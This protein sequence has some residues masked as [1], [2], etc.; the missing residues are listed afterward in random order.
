MTSS[1][2][3]QRPI[4]A[5]SSVNEFF[6]KTDVKGCYEKRNSICA[7]E[8]QN[9][10]TNNLV[11]DLRNLSTIPF[12]FHDIDS[13]DY[14]DGEKF[15]PIAFHSL[16][17]R[18][19]DSSNSWLQSEDFEDFPLRHLRNSI[20]S[21]E[22][23]PPTPSGPEKKSDDFYANVGDAIRTLRRELPRVFVDE[24]TYDIYREDIVFRDPRNN[25]AGI[26]NYKLIFR[27]L[28]AFGRIFFRPG[29]LRLEILRIW[30]PKEEK[31][32]VRWCIRGAGWFPWNRDGQF[33]ATSEFK[34][35][36][37]GKIYEHKVD[38]VTM[39]PD[40]YLSIFSKMLN[41]RVEQATPTPSFY[42]S[43]KS[44]TIDKKETT[45]GDLTQNSNLGT[46]V[47]ASMFIDKSSKCMSL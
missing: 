37:H 14:W 10:Y 21:I 45:G 41:L 43:H 25:F 20:Q 3:T 22:P 39:D 16:S 12:I 19:V 1:A 31:I 28:R 40:G 33:D 46:E 9:Q 17:S 26:K 42:F 18:V 8:T 24:I 36:S 11:D 30:Q 6:F 23:P 47:L 32:V 38:N 5:N 35:D 4:N 27:T 15:N 34:L 2:R 7:L 29:T 44:N 13:S